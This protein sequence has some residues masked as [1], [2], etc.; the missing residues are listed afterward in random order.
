[1]IFHVASHLLNMT[2]LHS[3]RFHF[4]VINSLGLR[5]QKAWAMSPAAEIDG[6]KKEQIG[7]T[8]ALFLQSSSFQCSEGQSSIYMNK[9]PT[10]T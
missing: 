3:K 1:M 4:C 5:C 9:K 6:Q 10:G 8:A 7:Y 2:F